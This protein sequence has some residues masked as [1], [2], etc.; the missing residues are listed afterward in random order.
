MMCML[1]SQRRN[2]DTLQFIG[3]NGRDLL[4][5]SRENCVNEVPYDCFQKS[6]LPSIMGVSGQVRYL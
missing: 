4:V 1:Y 6:S 3:D 2:C 5:L